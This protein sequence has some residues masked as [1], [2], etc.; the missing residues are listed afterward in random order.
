MSGPAAKRVGI[1]W[2]AEPGTPLAESRYEPV[3][4]ALVR[5]GLDVEDV[6]FSE[7]DVDTVRTQLLDLDGVLVWVDPVSNGKSRSVLDPLLRETAS[8][9]V[10]V[11]T[12]PNV[13]LKMG[14]KDVL[15]KT[16]DMAW[17]SDCQL[18]SSL[19]EMTQQ[20]PRRLAPGPLVLKQHRGNGGNGVWKVE[21][22]GQ[23]PIANLGSP[24][25]VLHAQRDSSVEEM[26]LDQFLD[27]CAIYFAASGCMIEQPYQARLADGMIRCYMI[28]DRVA[29]FG[30]QFVTALLAPPEGTIRSPTPPPRLYYGPAKPEFQLIKARLEG[31]WIGEMQRVLGIDTDE[32]PALWDADFLYGPKDST[33]NDTFVLCEINVSCVSPFPNEALEPLAKKVATRLAPSA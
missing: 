13:I 18:Y 1:L 29:G 8:Q 19:E 5:Q 7:E 30:H 2:R 14:T 9:G 12:H 27:R 26:S 16:R 3:R 20:L 32:L 15:V 11:S 21:G 31:G 23:S 22:F 33:G 28:G 4:D 10:W 25:R 24:V 17:G 6:P